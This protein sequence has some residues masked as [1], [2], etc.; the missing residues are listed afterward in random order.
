MH[1]EIPKDVEASIHAKA[2]A[3]GFRTVEEYVLDLVGH[4]EASPD[5]PRELW[6]RNFD[7]LVE[8]QKSRN[9]RFDDSRESIYPVR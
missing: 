2:R 9:S 1:L 8:R 6:L 7:A 4:E 5:A 3:A